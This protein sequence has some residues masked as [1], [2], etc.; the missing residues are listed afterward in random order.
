MESIPLIDERECLTLL[1]N[2]IKARD[3][4]K[5]IG[6]LRDL[7]IYIQR[8]VANQSSQGNSSINQ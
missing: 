7:V 2:M 1:Q 8:V 5:F 6:N 4:P 3:L